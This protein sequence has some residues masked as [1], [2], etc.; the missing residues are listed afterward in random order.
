MASGLSE[1]KMVDLRTGQYSQELRGHSTCVF[2]CQ[3]SPT[4]PYVLATGSYD[5]TIRLWDA[6]SSKACFAILDKDNRR[7]EENRHSNLFKSHT[8]SVNGLQF[9]PNGRLLISLGSDSTARCWD[10]HS[11]K[12]LDIPFGKIHNPEL[13]AI[14][15]ATCGFRNRHFCFIPDLCTVIVF[16][17]ETG[18]R[19][20]TLLG[21]YLKVN[22]CYFQ[23]ESMEL[24]SGGQDRNILMY[25]VE[26][27]NEDESVVSSKTDIK[28]DWTSEDEDYS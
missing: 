13:R 3:W 14:E 25:T 12:N 2:C 4:D 15:F 19:I 26:R 1:V 22:T 8:G 10:L 9:T 17:L 7:Q 20:K 24:Y 5:S 18:T 16:E 21:H 23:E 6:R 28:H 27:H 11:L